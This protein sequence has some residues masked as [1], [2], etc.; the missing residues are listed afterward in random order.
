MKKIYFALFGI[1]LL[2]PAFA[3]EKA[4]EKTEGAAEGK[5]RGGI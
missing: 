3:A 1:S 5:I 2:L 4:A